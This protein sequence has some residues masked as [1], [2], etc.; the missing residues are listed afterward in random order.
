[1]PSSCA[2]RLGA[3]PGSRLVL[4][5]ARVPGPGPGQV[6]VAVAA[7]AVCRTGL[8]AVDGEPGTAP[9]IIRGQETIGRIEVLG[10]GATAPV[11]GTR[12][13]LPW[14]RWTCGFRRV[15]ATGGRPAASR[16]ASPAGGSTAAMPGAF[17]PMRASAWP[18]PDGE[19]DLDAASLLCDGPLGLPT[20]RAPGD[21]R[22][23]G[24]HRGAAG[25]AR[26]PRLH[27]RGDT[28]ARDVARRP[29][30][31]AALARGTSGTAMR[32]Q[33][34]PC[35]SALDR[36]VR[37]GEGISTIAEDSAGT[38]CCLSGPARSFAGTIASGRS[39]RTDRSATILDETSEKRT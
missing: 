37:S 5:C 35:T 10:R 39:A 6:R 27:P 19:A 25:A 13:H 12:A 22:R 1:M 28:A 18:S 9:G 3:G 20:L 11:P 14:L 26:G 24:A 33:C 15:C 30:E 21:A 23:G 4:P 7:R 32:H 8:H 2:M 34:A 36:T 31:T 16:R 38:H 17:S 29:V